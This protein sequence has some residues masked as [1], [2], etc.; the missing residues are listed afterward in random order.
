MNSTYITLTALG[1]IYGVSSKEVGRWLKNMGLRLE[2]GRPSRDAVKQGFVLECPLQHGG[3]FWTWHQDKTCH[4]LDQMCYP[5]WRR[6]TV[7]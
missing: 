6:F 4:E 1:Q 7:C 3:Y 5:P 2:D